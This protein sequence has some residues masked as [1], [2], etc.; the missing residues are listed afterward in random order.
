VRFVEAGGARISAIG[1]GAWQ[2]GSFEWGYGEDYARREALEIVHR[3]L[4]LGVNLIDTAEFYGFGRSERI[5]GEAIKGHRTRC[6]WPPRYSRSAFRFRSRR[7]RAGAR[8]G[9]ES[10]GSTCTSSTGP[11]RC[12]RLA[13]PCRA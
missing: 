11:A 7:G 8:A 1:L 12:S 2:F 4:E 3:A 5:V 13:R 10:I 6:F 9:L